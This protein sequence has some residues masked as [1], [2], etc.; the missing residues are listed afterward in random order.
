MT[1]QKGYFRVADLA[2][3]MRLPTH[4]VRS[5]VKKYWHQAD[6]A[7][8]GQTTAMVKLEGI[9]QPYYSFLVLIELV[10]YFGLREAGVPPRKISAAHREL[11]IAYE[12]AHPFAHRLILDKIEVNGNDISFRTAE[13]TIILNGK[14][15]FNLPFLQNFSRQIDFGA[16]FI[17]TKFWPM[18]KDNTIVVDPSRRF[19]AP[20]VGNTNIYPETLYQM[21]QAEGSVAVVANLY[22]VDE[23]EVNDAIAFCAAAA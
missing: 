1:E 7:A 18:G 20:L 13:G 10:V 8:L 15:Q 5:W 4:T 19:G 23:A 2:Q 3:I 22:E 16:D 11:S 14:K 6:Q 12:T 21:Y 9:D 17:A